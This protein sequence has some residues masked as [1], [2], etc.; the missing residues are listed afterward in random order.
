M[1]AE[2]PMIHRLFAERV[3]TDPAAPALLGDFG[4]VSYAALDAAAEAVARRLRD[5]GARRGAIVAVLVPRGPSFV[6]TLLGILKAGAAYL[7]LTAGLPAERR[8]AMIERSG[9][10]IAVATA[11]TA[12]LLASTGIEILMAGAACE[13]ATGAPVDG[14][15]G[16]EDLAYVTYTSGSTGRPKGSL[17]PHRAMTGFFFGNPALAL[18]PG[19][20]FLQHSSVLWDALTLELWP[21]LASGAAVRLMAD[22]QPNPV[23]VAAVLAAGGISHLWLSASS[24]HVLVDEDPGVFAGLR[25]LLVGGEA[26]SPAHV[27]KLL[28]RHTGL[29][30]WNGYGPSECTV[31]ATCHPVPADIDPAARAIPIGRPIGDRVVHLLDGEMRPVPIGVAGEI[32]VGGPAVA[33]GYLGEPALTAERFVPDP[34]ADRPGAR[35]YRTGDF[36]R[37]LAGGA[38][39]FAGR[40]DDQVKLRGYRIELGEIEARLRADPEIR[41]AAC[42]LHTDREGSLLVAYVVP[43]S[44]EDATAGQVESWRAV[45]DERIYADVGRRGDGTFE[46]AGWNSSYDGRPIPDTAMRDWAGD[47]TAQ[48]RALGARR[49]LEVGCGTGLLLLDLARDAERYVGTDI[50]EAALAHV[51][52]VIATDP[53]RWPGVDLKRQPADDTTGLDPGGFDLIILSSVIQ[54]FPSADYLAAVL[55]GLAPLLAEGGAILAADVRHLG[56]MR[57]FHASVASFKAA[58]GTSAATLRGHVDQRLAGE[59]ELHVDPAFFAT[60]AA[61]HPGL[62]DVRIRL[63]AGRHDNEMT[64]FRYSAVVRRAPAPAG[65]PVETLAAPAD[66]V[67]V[68]GRLDAG[69]AALLVT[70]MTNDRLAGVLALEAAL[71][72]GTATPGRDRLDEPGLHPEDVRALAGERGYA[73]ELGWSRGD[74]GRFDA[75]FHREFPPA[76]LPVAEP[77]GRGLQALANRPQRAV[78]VA[79]LV[80][81]IRA[82]LAEALP[83]Y[84]IPAQFVLLER[85]PLGSTGKL[86]RRALPPPPAE[87]AAAAAHVEPGTALERVLAGFYSEL[88][89]AERVGLTD[90]FFDLGGHSLLVTQLASRIRKTFRINLPLRALFEAPTVAALAALVAESDMAGTAARIAEA[91][92]A[93]AAAATDRRSA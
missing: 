31:F 86:D 54:Y 90:N 13:A 51:R 24:F 57:S 80:P 42:V 6:A 62:G 92:L 9:C 58:P 44:A 49:V 71:A 15:A 50:S 61:R 5:A 20:V 47:I 1:T 68:A 56:L 88:L 22:P 82:R 37:R 93:A 70:G 84:M 8:A 35:L 63:Q 91:H 19:D 75:L 16:P 73:V 26:P 11:E 33:L 43:T 65:S 10:R 78:E 52:G 30:V 7:P 21:A 48:A 41:D 40:R 72:A 59:R 3:R 4:T 18:G 46:T 64:R 17:V 2:S 83:D 32:F 81:A 23:D 87:R 29:A 53:A 25:T 66:L 38:I 36:G 27:R 39:E 45:F 85:M 55:D 28:D 67:P 69:P 89:G 34:F 79:E 76:R 60:F 77:D 12:G 14:G 74:P